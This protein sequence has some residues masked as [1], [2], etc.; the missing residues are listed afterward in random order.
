MKLV[1]K[2]GE[3]YCL[4]YYLLVTFFFYLFLFYL[5][6]Y[7]CFGINEIYKRSVFVRGN[8]LVCFIH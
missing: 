3:K 2:D 7:I 6:I 5:F 4:R 8:T 1:E